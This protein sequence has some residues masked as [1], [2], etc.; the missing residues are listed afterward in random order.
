M[1]SVAALYERDGDLFHP[2]ELTRGPWSP[3]A[4][5]GGAPGALLATLA[6]DFEGGEGMSVTRLTIELLRPVPLSPLRVVTSLER[7]GYK[8]QLVGLSM[9]AGDTEVA[10]ARVL[11]IRNK[12]VELPANL[13]A[14]NPP[15]GPGEGSHSLP[16]WHQKTGELGFHSHAVEHRFV[17]GAF[18]RPGPSV[19]WIRLRVPVLGGGDTPPAARAVAAADFGNGVSWELDRA[20]GYSF[21]NPDLTVYLLRPPAGEWVCLQAR[22]RFDRSGIGL[23]ES[24]LWDERGVVGR[25]VQSLLIEGREPGTGNREP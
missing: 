10:R 25:S 9:R 16:R 13:T 21:I 20:D 23:A 2:S 14:D 19:D 17:E 1:S 22:S 5:H 15:P 3:D 4:Q 7:P 12:P 6:H 11:R 24:L 18:D 8:V